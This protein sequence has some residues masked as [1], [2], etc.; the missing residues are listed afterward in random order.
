MARITGI[1]GFFIRSDDPER[2]TEWYRSVLGLGADDHGEWAQDAGAGVFAAMPRDGEQLPAGRSIMVN[3]RV[4][5][6]D[7][8]LERLR[9]AGADV[10]DERDDIDGV[11]RFGWVTDPDGNRIELWEPPLEGVER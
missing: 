11:G 1:G 6:L 5:D 10:A 8:V 3:L 9:A 2:L 7:G 4:D